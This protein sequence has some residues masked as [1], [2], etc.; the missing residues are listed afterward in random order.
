MNFF[1][2]MLGSK[3]KTVTQ[4][5]NGDL[6]IIAK[7]KDTLTGLYKELSTIGDNEGNYVLRVVDSAPWGWDAV[8]S[9][10]K[11]IT[12]PTVEEIAIFDA[13]E[14]RDTAN[15]IS[16][17]LLKTFLQKYNQF[18]LIVDN[19]LNEEVHFTI[20]NS[21]GSGVYSIAGDDVAGANPIAYRYTDGTWSAGSQRIILQANARGIN[22]SL[23]PISNESATSK[24]YFLHKDW[25]RDF[26]MDL[27]FRVKCITAPTSGSITVTLVGRA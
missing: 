5:D 20:N 16:S 12:R 25:I 2:R 4:N 26:N 11:V 8:T 15:V 24:Y 3:E 1:T 18:D 22:A 17:V 19:E 27:L 9:T 10:T 6:E 14:I 21:E 13:V 7:G 23:F